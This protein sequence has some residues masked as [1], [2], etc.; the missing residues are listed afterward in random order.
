MS[1]QMD[2][3]ITL[4]VICAFITRTLSTNPNGMFRI[5]KGSKLFWDNDNFDFVATDIVTCVTYCFTENNQLLACNYN[6]KTMSCFCIASIS[7]LTHEEDDKFIS[8]TKV[9]L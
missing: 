1:D 6:V 8:A 2:P 3:R 7:A 5:L 9:I 4:I